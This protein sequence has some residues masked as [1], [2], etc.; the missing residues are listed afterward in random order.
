MSTSCL[1]PRVAE[2]ARRVTG[3][4]EETAG[5]RVTPLLELLRRQP[6]GRVQEQRLARPD[7]QRARAAPEPGLSLAPAV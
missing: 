4:L 3:A 5:Q 1:P 6:M 7:P 2:L